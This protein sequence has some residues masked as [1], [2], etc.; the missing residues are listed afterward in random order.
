M[1]L[2][3]KQSPSLYKYLVYC[4]W[5]ELNLLGPLRLHSLAS[6]PQGILI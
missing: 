5:T 6:M 4:S 3:I 2:N 1:W